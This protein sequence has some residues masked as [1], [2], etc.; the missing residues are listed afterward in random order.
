MAGLSASPRTRHARR[1]F[2]G[3]APQYDLMAELLSFG[4]NRVEHRLERYVAR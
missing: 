2:A 1:L 4:Q 3:I